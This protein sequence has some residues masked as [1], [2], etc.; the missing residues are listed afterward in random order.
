MLTQDVWP[1]ESCWVAERVSC[2]L[3]AQHAFHSNHNCCVKR[4]RTKDPRG[5]N[6]RGFLC[7]TMRLSSGDVSWRKKKKKLRH[8]CCIAHKTKKNLEHFPQNIV[9][10]GVWSKSSPHKAWCNTSHRSACVLPTEAPGRNRTQPRTQASP[11][12]A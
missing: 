6:I 1:P 8:L 9:G 5:G 10:T 12:V 3:H 11:A 7:P 2:G 4:S